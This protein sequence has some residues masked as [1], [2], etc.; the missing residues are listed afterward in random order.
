M[1]QVSIFEEIIPLDSS[2][3]LHI[4]THKGFCSSSR[5]LLAKHSPNNSI[6]VKVEKRPTE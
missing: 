5:L 6:V 4:R 2:N 3:S 1:I